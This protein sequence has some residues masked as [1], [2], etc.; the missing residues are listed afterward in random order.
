[1]NIMLDKVLPDELL[2]ELM[3][4]MENLGPQHLDEDE[5]P[6]LPLAQI[7]AKDYWTHSAVEEGA[8]KGY[9]KNYECAMQSGSPHVQKVLP[10][11]AQKFMENSVIQ[12]VGLIDCLFPPRFN[13]YS[14]GCFYAEHCD[15]P[16]ARDGQGRRLRADLAYTLWLSEPEDYTGGELVIEDGMSDPQVYKGKAGSMVLYPSIHVHRVN[17]VKDGVRYAV[18]GWA[19]SLISDIALRAEVYRVNKM[20]DTLLKRKDRKL[21]VRL[22]AHRNVLLRLWSF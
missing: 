13:K 6:A 1:M 3:E 4:L 9:K 21:F 10:I 19:Q 5:D 17:E 12:S 22:E 20:L 16:L 7:K 2:P 14:R 8:M 15:E 11:I 18:V